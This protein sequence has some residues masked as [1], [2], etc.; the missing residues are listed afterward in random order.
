MRARAQRSL[1]V[2]ILTAAVL[3]G[4]AGRTAPP[5]PSIVFKEVSV[6]VAVGCVVNR[7][8]PPQTLGQRIPAEQWKELAP[9]AM[10]EAVKA[11]AGDRL[12]YEDELR[13]ATLGCKDAPTPTP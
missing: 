9:G 4:C 5:E 1:S 3:G 13:A 12:N 2:G 6:P 7:P 10:A 11:Q 8:V